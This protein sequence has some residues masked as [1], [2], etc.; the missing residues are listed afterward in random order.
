MQKLSGSFRSF[1]PAQR[2]IEGLKE[3]RDLDYTNDLFG[4]AGKDN[5]RHPFVVHLE[6]N[7]IHVSPYI[8]HK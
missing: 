1:L 5:I 4:S 7:L 6:D 2:K 8:S 3:E